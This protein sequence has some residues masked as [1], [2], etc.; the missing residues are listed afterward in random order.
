MSTELIINSTQN[1]CRIALLKDKKL[2]EYHQD[3]D[4]HQFNVGDI[5]LGQVKKVVPGLNA[6]FV[7]IGY[8]KDAF[9]HYLDLGP[10]LQSLN[11]CTK[12]ILSGKMSGK[13]LNGFKRLPDINKLGKMNQVLSKNQRVLV[14][15][16]KEPISTKGPRLSSELS[17]AGRYIVLVPFSDSVSVS[18]KIADSN[19]R[20]RLLRLIKSIKPENF[21]IIIRTVAQGKDVAELD[22]DLTSLVDKWSK[23]MQRLKKVK[24][25]EKV[26]GEINRANSILRD[27]LNESF[28]SIV[29]DDKTLYHEVRNFIRE[30]APEKEKSTKLYNGRAKVFEA[31]GIEKQLKGLFGQSVS[32]DGGG[33]LIIEHTEALHVIDVNSGN[34]S[35]AEDNQESTALKVNMDAAKEIARQLRLRDMGGIIV[36]DFID[37][38]KVE[39]K[40]LLFQ[41][42]KDEMKTDRSKFTV[43]PLSKFGLMQITRQRVRPELNIKTR[44]VCPSCNGSGKITASILVTDQ[45][46][47]DIEH[48]MTKQNEKKLTI[49]LHPYLYAYFTSGLVSRRMKW[50]FKYKRWISLAEDS[51]KAILEYNFINGLGEEIAL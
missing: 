21:G 16:V 29:I 20:K 2:T 22:R 8:E 10:Q 49:A 34:K 41:K 12:L 46:E 3:D 19:E 13:N 39:N 42:M 9:L 43:L 18:K 24:P 30:I 5:Y 31:Y 1:G 37:M 40:K 45:I 50:Y 32:I 36:I 35:N 7:D 14:Q 51:S 25:N 17:I 44:E 26:I 23:G 4:G 48:L 6:A 11:K 38:R 27:V 15:V 47:K 33:Y 28:D